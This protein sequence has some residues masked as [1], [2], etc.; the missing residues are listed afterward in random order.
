[1]HEYSSAY[2]PTGATCEIDASDTS[3][4]CDALNEVHTMLKM[5][6]TEMRNFPQDIENCWIELMLHVHM[7]YSL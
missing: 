1:M 6:W 5:C 7:I 3:A 2:Q 4:V